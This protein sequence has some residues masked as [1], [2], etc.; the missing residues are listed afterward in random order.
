LDPTWVTITPQSVNLNEGERAAVNIAITPPRLPTSLAGTQFF[1]ITVTSP[2]YPNHVSQKS[3]SLTIAPFYEFAV[4]ELSP[5]TQ[6]ISYRQRSGAASLPIVNKGNSEVAY[7]IDGEDDARGCSFEF[8][9]PG[10]DVSLA[11]QAEFRLPPNTLVDVPIRITPNRRHVFGMRKRNFSL[12]L[13]TIPLDGQQ[14]PRSVLGQ[15][16]AAP[17]IGPWTVLLCLVL[18]TL[19]IAWIFHPTIDEFKVDKTAVLA[20]QP[21]T[22]SWRASAFADLKI[23]NGV[24][25]VATY[26]GTMQVTPTQQTTTYHLTAENL[27]TRLVPQWFSA[28]REVT[29]NVVP[30]IP[31]LQLAVV[32]PSGQRVPSEAGSIPPIMHGESV[33]LYWEVSEADTLLLSANGAP[34]TIQPAEFIGKRAFTP[35]KDTD[36]VL[37]ARN[38]YDSPKKSLRIRVN[39]PPTQTPTPT[40]TIPPPTVVRF[41]ISPLVITAGQTIKIEWE[42]TNADTVVID[43]VQGPNKFP[44]KGSVNQNPDKSTSYVLTAVNGPNVVPLQRDVVVNPAPTATPTPIPPKVETFQLTRA[45]VVKGSTEAN[46]V[47]IVWLVSGQT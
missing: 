25:T 28:E 35:D 1:T 21:V 12:T 36:F 29:V 2:N 43:G 20:K 5:R 8:R 16:Q 40:P 26:Q 14:T 3:G 4:G 10:H 32:L 15:L 13:N 34:E 11:R 38:K 19:L 23:D 37:E 24:G 45:S 41:D 42:V 47:K 18:M 44:P 9:V 33:T 27:L 22:L 46:D 17:L 39:E 31:S 6:S 7:R 30:V